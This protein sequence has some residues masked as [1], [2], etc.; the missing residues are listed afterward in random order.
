MKADIKPT[1]ATIHTHLFYVFLSSVDSLPTSLLNQYDITTV[2]LKVG[3]NLRF[4][5][6]TKSTQDKRYHTPIHNITPPYNTVDTNKP[7]KQKYTNNQGSTEASPPK[8][9]LTTL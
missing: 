9:V 1:P 6:T 5:V 2:K 8:I 7:Q 3:F 4:L